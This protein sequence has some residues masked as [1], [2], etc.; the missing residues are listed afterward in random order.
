MLAD[1]LDR[2]LIN[3]LLNDIFVFLQNT[4]LSNYIGINSLIY[5]NETKDRGN[6]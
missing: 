5:C 6:K 4:C 2:F 1:I 3:I